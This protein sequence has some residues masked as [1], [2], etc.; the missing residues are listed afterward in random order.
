[1]YLNF[2]MVKYVRRKTGGR[3][4]LPICQG[5]RDRPG[6]SRIWMKNAHHSNCHGVGLSRGFFAVLRVEIIFFSASQY[7]DSLRAGR[8]GDRIPV[9]GG[10]DF[11]QLSRPAM[12]PIQPPVQWVPGLY[13]GRGVDHPPPS[14]AEVKDRVELYLY[15]PSGSSW[16]VLGW[17]L[18]LLLPMPLSV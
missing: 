14:S 6:D 5:H 12:G 11:P 17:T 10:R 7:S 18:S 2:Q 4:Q 3:N 1:M 16:P 8:F 9:G 13:L 15:S